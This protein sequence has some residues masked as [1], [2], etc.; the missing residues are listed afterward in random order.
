[1]TR[2]FIS[3]LVWGAVISFLLVAIVSL[4]GT[5]P[6]ETPPSTGA[7]DVPPGSEFNQSR[8]DAPVRLPAQEAVSKPPEAESPAPPDPDGLEGMD[9]AATA[10]GARPETGAPESELVAAPPPEAEGEAPGVGATGDAPVATI[11]ADPAP[12]APVAEAEPVRPAEPAEPPQTAP[13]PPD[14]PA[15]ADDD[16]A[17]ASGGFPT[18]DLD[19]AAEAPEVRLPGQS[20]ATR[21]QPPEAGNAPSAEVA[22]AAPPEAPGPPAA[23]GTVAPESAP[24]APARDSAAPRPSPS[25][26]AAAPAPAGSPP[27]QVAS[28][29]ELPEAPAQPDAGQAGIEDAPALPAAEPAPPSGTASGEE[30][31][32]RIAVPEADAPAAPAEN[33]QAPQAQARPPE[34]E[35]PGLSSRLAGR[36]TDRDTGDRLSQRL[37]T[38]GAGEAGGAASTAPVAEAEQSAEA[39]SDQPPIRRY[40]EPFSNPEGQPLMSIVL[41][42][43]GSGR[44]EPES[45]ADFP[46][47]VTVAL[48][49]AQDGAAAAMEAYRAAGVEVMLLANFDETATP[50]DV[51]TAFEVWTRRL[52]QT[53][54]VMEAPGLGLQSSRAVSDQVAGI[55]ADTGR[56]LVLYPNGFDTARKLAVAE[57]VPAAT[58]FRD[59][60]AQGQSEDVIRRF[61]DHAAFR[62]RQEGAVIMVGRARAE[63]VEALLVWALQDRASQVAMAPISALLLREAG[64]EG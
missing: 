36:L 15:T 62:A 33:P 48:D 21:A 27:P 2:G 26:R 38:I 29:A 28:P 19:A 52:P 23:P 1:M 8:E 44:V 39:D 54:A 25:G 47:P 10:P 60:D 5:L 50:Q 42:D 41:L 46:Y 9:P 53:V 57:G 49:P 34:V 20:S 4:N 6:G 11:A 31:V 40:A 37:P 12:E 63:T 45:F 64:G 51:E 16:A 32:A 18:Q 35:E 3:G 13:A 59:F 17:D 14:Q 24:T 22:T 43:D 55:L 56:G 30:R 58:V 7:A 61:L